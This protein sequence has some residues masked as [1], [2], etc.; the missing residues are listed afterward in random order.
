MDISLP[1]RDALKAQA[2]R[3]RARLGDAG[4]QMSHAMALEAVAHQWGLRDWNTLCAL[5]QDGPT[6]QWQVGQRITGR[7]LGHPFQGTIKTASQRAGGFWR[8]TIRFDE[9]VD[10][11]RSDK[12]S[13]LRRQINCSVDARGHSP[14]KTS[15]GRPQVVLSDH[16]SRR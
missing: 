13:C 5:A 4:H 3:L 10:V 11:V 1:S 2:R 8:L 16:W 14:Q 6:H 7:Y 15:D 9:P 12:F